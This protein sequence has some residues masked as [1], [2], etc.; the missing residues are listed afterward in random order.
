M[1]SWDL[2]VVGA[3]PAGAATAIGALR[4]DPSLLEDA[5]VTSRL[6]ATPALAS[7]LLRPIA[8]PGRHRDTHHSRADNEEATP[9]EF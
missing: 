2:A 7:G 5:G 3:D 4:A 6:A 1:S 8:T 9:C